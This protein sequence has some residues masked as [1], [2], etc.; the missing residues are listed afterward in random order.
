M[1]RRSIG[2]VT[3]AHGA[4]W[5][6]IQSVIRRRY[7]LVTVVLSAA[8]VQ[9]DG[10]VESIVSALAAL[11]Q[12]AQADVVIVARGG[13]ASDDLAA[14]NDERVVRAI[15]ACRVPV[16]AGIGHATDRTLAED[17]ADLAA[18]T[19][20]AAAEMCVPSAAE[21]VSQLIM[22][23]SR[24]DWAFSTALAEA[25]SRTVAATGLLSVSDPRHMAKRHRGQIADHSARL[26][27]LM[28]AVH[29]HRS[30]DAG[31]AA[32]LLNALNP[33]AILNR[34]YA[35]VQLEPGGDPLFS[36]AQVAPG[37]RLVARLQ[38]GSVGSLIESWRDIRPL[39][40]RRARG[41]RRARAPPVTR[42]SG[43][44]P[45]GGTIRGGAYRS[46]GRRCAPR[47]RPSPSRR[48]REVVRSRAAAVAP[49]SRP[50]RAGRASH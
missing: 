23:R 2:V 36:T 29:A 18:V 1:A 20:S 3:S 4:A 19:P 22:H 8:Q 40:E 43:S 31:A 30:R 42:S 44:S 38:D 5:N 13:G 12:D 50:A 24:I 6:D 45:P 33:T 48:R 39:A 10:A 16:V 35:A 17:A 7:P 15:F 14:F 32:S 47:A 49:V 41:E 11:Q 37:L 21:L 28:R 34:G 25:R 27:R 46:P 9:G 26:S